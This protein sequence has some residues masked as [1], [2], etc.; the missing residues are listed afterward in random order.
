MMKDPVVTLPNCYDCF[1]RCG[2]AMHT[3]RSHRRI[4]IRVIHCWMQHRARTRM[5][6]R[7]LGG[8]MYPPA[9]TLIER[10]TRLPRFTYGVKDHDIRH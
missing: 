6:N 9:Q 10:S 5:P 8:V 1:A 3:A 2:R 7:M 4:G